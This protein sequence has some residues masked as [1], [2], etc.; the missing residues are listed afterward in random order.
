MRSNLRKNSKSIKV[1]GN[2]ASSNNWNCYHPRVSERKWLWVST[3]VN[4]RSSWQ[5]IR[6]L[7][8]NLF[9]GLEEIY[10]N[11]R[12]PPLLLLQM[13]CQKFTLLEIFLNLYRPYRKSPSILLHFKGCR[14]VKFLIKGPATRDQVNASLKRLH[15]DEINYFLRPH[16]ISEPLWLVMDVNRLLYWYDV[17]KISDVFS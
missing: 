13:K 8:L 6:T 4:S 5:R 11:K 12:F 16:F 10:R 15:G 3:I 1:I 7:S 2:F 14:R 17:D 9:L